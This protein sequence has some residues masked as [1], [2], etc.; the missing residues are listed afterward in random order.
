MKTHPEVMIV[1]PGEHPAGTLQ[2]L[3][4]CPTCGEEAVDRAGW[5]QGGGDHE[6]VTIQPDRDDYDSPIG[7]RGG[8]LRVDL[9]CV[10]GHGFALI[11]ANH[12]GAEYLGVVPAVR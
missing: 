9:E 6:A 12:K 5:T 1:V 2:W 10:A 8:Y 3:L 7:T 4:C 11:V